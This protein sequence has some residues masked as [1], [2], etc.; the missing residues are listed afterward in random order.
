MVGLFSASRH[1]S[2]RSSSVSFRLEVLVFALVGVMSDPML[3][4]DK[5]VCTETAGRIGC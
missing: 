4:A 1:I 2:R 3:V 5:G